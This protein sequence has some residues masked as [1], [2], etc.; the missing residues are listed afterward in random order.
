[1][2]AYKVTLEIHTPQ[3]TKSKEHAKE[4]VKAFILKPHGLGTQVIKEIKRTY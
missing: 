2:P 1:M 4:W 3:H